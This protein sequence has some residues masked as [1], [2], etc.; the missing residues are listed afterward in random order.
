MSRPRHPKKEIEAAV[1]Y[2]EGLGWEFVKCRGHVWGEL[3]CPHHQRG[4][5][6]RRVFSTP[7]NP[8]RHARDIRHDVDCC[9]HQEHES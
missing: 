2:A 3:Y 9:P 1:Q 8:E 7:R 5:C 4:G 6:I